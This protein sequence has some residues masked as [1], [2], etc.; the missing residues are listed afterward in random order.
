MKPSP[1][2][3]YNPVLK[4]PPHEVIQPPGSDDGPPGKGGQSSGRKG[5]RGDLHCQ[6]LGGRGAQ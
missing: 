4:V 6:A 2:F 1:A 5:Q 3:R